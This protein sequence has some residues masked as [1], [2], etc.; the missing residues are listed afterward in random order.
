MPHPSKD[1][2]RWHH[3]EGRLSCAVI[4]NVTASAAHCSCEARDL[5]TPYHPPYSLKRHAHCAWVLPSGEAK[6]LRLARR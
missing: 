3:P 5:V 1:R 6:G 4:D 2:H